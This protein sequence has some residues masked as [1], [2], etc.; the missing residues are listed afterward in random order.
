MHHTRA[1]L[2]ALAFLALG[3]CSTEPARTNP[4]DEKAPASVQAKAKVI[5]SLELEA[6]T[7]RAGDAEDDDE[8]G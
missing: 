6:S 1:C 4:F 5:G 7:Q 8:G 2:G 3:S